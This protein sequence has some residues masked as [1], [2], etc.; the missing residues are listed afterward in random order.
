[1]KLLVPLFTLFTGC[2]EYEFTQFDGTDVF[3]QKSADLVDILLVV[4]NSCS[5]DPYQEKLSQNFQAFIQFFVDVDIDYHI[6]VVTTT[7]NTPLENVYCNANDISRIPD[8]GHLVNGLVIDAETENPEQKFSNAVNV[9]ICGSGSEMGLEAAALALSPELLGGVNDG[10][11][12]EEAELSIIFVSDEEDSSPA[13]VNDYLNMYRAVKGE[14][15][16]GAFDASAL[17]VTDKT[18]CTR[19]QINAGATVGSRYMDVA[20]QGAGVQGN[21]CSS[22]FATVV[23][24]L[25]L[26]ASRLED[27]FYLSDMPD[28]T[29]LAVSVNATS[30]P[31]E[32]GAWTYTIQVD[33]YGVESPVVIFERTNLPPP[34][35]QI[36]IRYYDGDGD[37]SLF[38]QGVE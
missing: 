29:T 11:I 35:S 18:E 1:M 15:N 21:I 36:A 24:D 23:T 5:M 33:E 13:P 8:P 9:G 22:D 7:V 4:D 20:V 32:D 19:D 3:Y 6:G 31:C 25:S 26:N 37:E 10:F 27:T 16:R 34:S 17:V 28:P 30:Y 38:C 14:R 12:R 2:V